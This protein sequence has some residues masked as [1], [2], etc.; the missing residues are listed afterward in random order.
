ML[1]YTFTN[2]ALVTIRTSG[3][4]PKIKWY[5]QLTSQ[6][7]DAAKELAELVEA[8]VATCLEPEKNGLL[9]ARA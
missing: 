5:A 7:P 4:E 3:T 2:N 9:P 8:L 6:S 1:T